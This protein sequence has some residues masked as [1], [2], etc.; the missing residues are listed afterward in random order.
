MSI[1]KPLPYVRNFEKM[2]F[3]L[4]VHWG[5][6]S[7][8]GEGEWARYLHPYSLEEYGK[9]FDTFTACDFDAEKL[10]CTAKNAG[11]NYITLTTRH[12]DGFSLYDTC[13]LS[14]FDAPHSPAGRDLIA[15]FVTACRKY[16]ITPFFYHTTI[17]W[18]WKNSIT[19][20]LSADDF[21]CYLDYLHKSVEILCTNYGKIGG[22]WFDGNWSRPNDDWKEDRLYGIIRKHQ[23]EAIIV[24]N[25]G[26]ENRGRLGHPEIDSVTYENGAA[27]PMDREGQP[28]YVAGEVCKTMNDHWGIGKND[29]NFLSPANVIELLAHSRGCGANLLLNIGPEAQGAIPAYEKSVLEKVGVWCKMYQEAIYNPVPVAGVKC[30]GRDFI[31]KDGK[32]YYYFV[33]DLGVLGDSNV[34]A[35][36]HGLGSRAIDGFAEKVKSV[37]WMDNDEK[38]TFIQKQENGML[39]IFC[40]GYPYGNN[41][42][43]RVAKI[44]V[45]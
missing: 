39:A 23:P 34:T 1:P 18:H 24:N 33:F 35:A 37:T 21:D 3:G 25:T 30:K 6:Y 7:Q 44:S 17:D 9:L 15:E 26:L 45:E 5:L 29:L 31:L 22:L 4:F 12:H 19:K 28:K 10:A 36:A 2:G 27:V 20:D 16:D 14:D 32:N 42:V 8:L 11:M 41:T 38:L 40:T 13:G 43:V